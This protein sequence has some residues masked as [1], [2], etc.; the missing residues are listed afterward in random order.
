[1]FDREV[2]ADFETVWREYPRK[3]GKGAARKVWARLQPDTEMV[4]KIHDAIAWQR[5]QPQWLK[6]HGA[7]IPH[8]ATW[9]NQERWED[10]PFH[11]PTLS[12][13]SVRMLQTMS[14]RS[15]RLLQ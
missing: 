8:L 14:Q 15:T 11:G 6:D 3:V 9:L 1:M 5:H 7:F 4:Q 13:K 2:I 10:E 12:E